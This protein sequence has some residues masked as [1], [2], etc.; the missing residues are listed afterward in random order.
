[1]KVLMKTMINNLYSII[2]LIKTFLISGNELET[3]SRDS[4][5]M[6]T[7]IE[8]AENSHQL[9]AE[10]VDQSFKD[11][12][13]LRFHQIPIKSDHF[14]GIPWIE[15]SHSGC[16]FRSTKDIVDTHIKQIHGSLLIK[17]PKIKTFVCE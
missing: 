10:E 13:S 11:K 9:K 15:C 14:K 3:T 17:K 5:Q 8:I 2:G 1:M 16:G 12:I 7:Q 4:N 6:T